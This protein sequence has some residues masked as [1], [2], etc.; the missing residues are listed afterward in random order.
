MHQNGSIVKGEIK[1]L[2]PSNQCHREWYFI[3]R[4][5]G[6]NFFAIFWPTDQMVLSYGCWYVHQIDDSTFQGFYLKLD[7]ADGGKIRTVP[8]TVKK[9]DSMGLLRRLIKVR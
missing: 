7:D 1:R 2:E 3:G 6:H 8:I 5:I 9:I 4:L